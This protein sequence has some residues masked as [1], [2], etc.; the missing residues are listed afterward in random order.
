MNVVI[1][2]GNVLETDI[3]TL[4][5]DEP[6]LVVKPMTLQEL[7]VVVKA[8]NSK[9]KAIQCGR[10]GE[11]PSGFTKFKANKILTLWIWNPSE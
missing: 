1:D 5:G 11:I 8:Y 6:V 2:N 7:M 9:T 3:P 10:S 4:F